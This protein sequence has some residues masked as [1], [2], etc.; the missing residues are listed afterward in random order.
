M[1]VELGQRVR[2]T[3]TVKKVRSGRPNRRTTH[4]RAGL[5]TTTKYYRPDPI[6]APDVW[7][8]QET[9]HGTGVVVGLRTV[10]DYDVFPGGY[11]E[12]TE[13]KAISGSHRTVVLVA[14]HLRR[15]PV[16]VDLDQIV[17]S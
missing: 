13:A 9:E 5:P 16:M 15:K 6:D 17:E 14:W 8:P 1:T 11:D 12:F 4:E 7:S 2:F 3:G 10:A